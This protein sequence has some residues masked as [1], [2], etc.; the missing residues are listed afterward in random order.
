MSWDEL[1]RELLARVLAR[2]SRNKLTLCTAACVSR[3]WR[4][5]VGRLKPKSEVRLKRLPD[6]V[7]QRLT[8]AGLAALVRR[9]R[10]RLVSLNLRGARLVTDKGLIAA[11]Q[12]RH[13][14][15]SFRA[16]IACRELT[17]VGVARA[18][19]SRRGRLSVLHVRGVRCLPY[20]PGAGHDDDAVST[21]R[22]ECMA[23]IGTLR[24]LVAPEGSLDGEDVCDGDYNGEL[25]ACI[26]GHN[27]ICKA[28]DQPWCGAHQDGRFGTCEDCG[29]RFC[30][31]GCL[32]DR[33]VCEGCASDDEY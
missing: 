2:V 24:E 17:A 19:A 16:D 30:E 6:A 11:L 13:A 32:D 1:P 26:C 23:A 14:L 33:G 21:W 12:Q 22:D 18:L 29:E 27:D 15:S 10:G 7:A 31:D 4:D 3:A 28:C 25:C 20:T 5:M 9:A 8:D